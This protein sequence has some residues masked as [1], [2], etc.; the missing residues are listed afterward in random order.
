MAPFAGS[1]IVPPVTMIDA[2]IEGL[3]QARKDAATVAP[4]GRSLD[5]LIAG[6][7]IRRPPTHADGRGTLTEIFDLRWGFTEDPLVYV[8]MAT[9][10]PGQV[11]G[12]VVHLEQNDRL[13][14]YAGILKI[15]LYDGRT[16]SATYRQLNVF[17]FGAHDRALVSIPAGVYH[18]VQ[19]VGDDE[20]AFVNL[21]SQPY[22]HEDPD[23]YRLPLE[24]D[25]IPYRF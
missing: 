2:A 16:E 5:E 6:V 12:W 10:R 8:Y 24:N 7:E 14:A 3:E 19:N 21:P 20:G 22:R 9:I 17:H 11:R 1:V 18:A 15:V 25:V 4:D 23:K 13:F